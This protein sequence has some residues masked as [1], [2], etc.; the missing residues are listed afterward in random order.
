M[1][2]FQTPLG[3]NYSYYKRSTFFCIKYTI[4]Y[5]LQ[6]TAYSGRAISLLLLSYSTVYKVYYIVY[7]T[8]YSYWF[9]PVELYPCSFCRTVQ[10]IK[11]AILYT[12]QYS[13]VQHLVLGEDVDG[14]CDPEVSRGLQPNPGSRQ[15]ERIQFTECVTNRAI[16]DSAG[17]LIWV[18]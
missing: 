13:T 18:I 2:L 8:G 1:F 6:D 14:T 9:T 5:T 16:D 10:Y 4:L 15:G 12:L 11:Y 7:I 3:C 17:S